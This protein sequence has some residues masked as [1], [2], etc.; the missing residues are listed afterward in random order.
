MACS[1]ASSR[2]PSTSLTGAAEPKEVLDELLA[3]LSVGREA[4]L[5]VERLV[6]AQSRVRPDEVE[7]VHL[8][9]VAVHVGARLDPGAELEREVERSA[10]RRRPSAAAEP[11]SPTRRSAP[12]SGSACCARSRA[13]SRWRRLLLLLRHGP[14]LVAGDAGRHL[15]RDGSTSL[16]AR[17]RAGAEGLCIRRRNRAA[18]RRSPAVL[19]RD[20][21]APLKRPS[22]GAVANGVPFPSIRVT[23]SSAAVAEKRADLGSASSSTQTLDHALRA[24]RRPSSEPGTTRTRSTT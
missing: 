21:T 5:D 6:M 16:E 20:R 17:S 24:S 13:S 12:C 11:P 10:A 23:A 8:V 2:T 15:A 7:V 1:R 9:A 18:A 19:A 3:L 22:S 4:G 14:L